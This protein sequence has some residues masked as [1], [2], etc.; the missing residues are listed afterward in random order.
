MPSNRPSLP[1]VYVECFTGKMIA[2]SNLNEPKIPGNKD[3]LQN[4][5]QN[6]LVETKFKCD[7]LFVLYYVTNIVMV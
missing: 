5:S 2:F 4:I 1:D 6:I 3:L 7:K